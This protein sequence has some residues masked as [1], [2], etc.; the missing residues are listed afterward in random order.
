ML[1]NLTGEV[2]AAMERKAELEARPKALKEAKDQIGS[3]RDFLAN[4]TAMAGVSIQATAV[5]PA[6]PFVMTRGGALCPRL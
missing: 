5:P 6:A 4:E 3:I 2:A 1:A